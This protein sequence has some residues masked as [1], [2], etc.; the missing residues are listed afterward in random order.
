MKENRL[1]AYLYIVLTVII[2]GSS[3]VFVKIGIEFCSEYLLVALRFL[4]AI[5]A[6]LFIF[7]VKRKDFTRGSILSGVF[8]GIFLFLGF[9][10]QTIS[11]KYTKVANTAFITGLFVIFI[12]FLSYFWEKVP[13]KVTSYFSIIVA[14]IGLYLLTGVNGINFNMGDILAFFSAMAFSIEIVAIQVSTR[15]YNPNSITL[16]SFI[17]VFIISS[18]ISIF[19]NQKIIVNTRLILVLLYLGVFCTTIA[20]G[21]QMRYQKYLNTVFV[22][23]LYLMEPVIA[24]VFAWFVFREYVIAKE[25]IGA[26]LILIS[27]VISEFPFGKFI[28]N[29]FKWRV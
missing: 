29:I 9:I 2:W 17:T 11:L 26:S 27:A 8:I 10:L 6:A 19:T 15:K 1:K 25:M 4:F 23:L 7:K 13:I 3:F 28:K 18:F 14:L 5:V 16:F 22:G 21:L 20:L 12:P 24:L